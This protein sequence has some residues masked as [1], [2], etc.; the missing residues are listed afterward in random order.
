MASE[1]PWV[2]ILEPHSRLPSSSVPAR[3]LNR[4]PSRIEVPDFSHNFSGLLF[5]M[6]ICTYVYMEC[7]MDMAITL[8]I[9]AKSHDN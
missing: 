3:T 5:A 7:T 2:V 9:W 8:V 6:P 4:V 1:W